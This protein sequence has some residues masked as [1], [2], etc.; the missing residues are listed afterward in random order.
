MN[1]LRALTFSILSLCVVT[2]VT[3]AQIPSDL[4]R[5]G[6]DGPVRT[7]KW[8]EERYRWD[9]S[10]W[11]SVG[12]PAHK[13]YRYDRNGR[14]LT[15]H[16]DPGPGWRAYGMPLSPATATGSRRYELVGKPSRGLGW[17]TVWQF[18]QEGRLGRYES[19]AVY[20]SGPD[21]S[22]WEQYSYDSQGRVETFTYWRNLGW[23]PNQ[24][25][26]YPPIRV[27]Y[28]FDN[29]GRIGG[30]TNL[31]NAKS[32]ST[33]TYD[34]KGRLVKQIEEKP[35][36]N[37]TYVRTYVWDSYDHHGNWTVQTF[38]ETWRTEEGDEPQSQTVTRRSIKYRR[39]RN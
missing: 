35:D 14:S 19:F 2:G 1:L 13:L 6:F 28:W 21:L 10:R 12:D 38:T 34:S 32:F 33:L 22:D 26:P 36:G 16:I 24:T 31:D 39:G 3:N 30:W 15:W 8:E 23:S 11:E 7:V 4:K 17:K 20:E 9:D 25:E 5:M 29:A 37:I 27:K 18:D